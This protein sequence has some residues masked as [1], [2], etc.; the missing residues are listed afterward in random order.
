LILQYQKEREEGKEGG[1]ME[2]VMLMATVVM[3]VTVMV[4]MTV[5][6]EGDGE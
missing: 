4:A 3:M 6:G 2:G 5:K 1:R